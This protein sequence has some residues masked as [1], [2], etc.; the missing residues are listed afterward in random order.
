[1]RL[2][3][4]GSMRNDTVL[5]VADALRA[6]GHDVH[7]D[8]F[9]PGSEADQRWT[10]YERRRGRTYNE[11][12]HGRHA[13]TVYEADK[14][15]IQWSD[16]VVLVQPAGKSAHMELGWA[17][18]DGK[19]GHILLDEEPERFDVMFRFVIESGGGV[20]NTLDELKEALG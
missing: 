6:D 11:A 8:W 14:R 4:I 16:A 2:Y 15:W 19:P 9:S 13:E 17:I 20:W 10:D 7:D 18:R 1:M 5:E 3:V 12:L